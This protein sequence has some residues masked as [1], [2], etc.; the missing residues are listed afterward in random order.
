MEPSL[1]GSP[2]ERLT[3]AMPAREADTAPATSAPDSTTG[4]STPTSAAPTPPAAPPIPKEIP[5]TLQSVA[6]YRRYEEYLKS[7][8]GEMDTVFQQ[9]YEYEPEALPAR[10]IRSNVRQ[11]MDSARDQILADFVDE[12]TGLTY[13]D[14]NKIQDNM[15]VWKDQLLN[16]ERPPSAAY[17]LNA[18]DQELQANPQIAEMQARFQAHMAAMPPFTERWETESGS[19]ESVRPATEDELKAYAATLVDPVTGVSGSDLFH[20]DRSIQEKRQGDLAM[21]KLEFYK[22]GSF[23][24]DTRVT[25]IDASRVFGVIGRDQRAQLMAEQATS[26]MGVGYLLEG[27]GNLLLP[28]HRDPSGPWF[29]SAMSA[30]DLAATGVINVGHGGY[31]LEG[32]AMNGSAHIG[33][34]RPN[35]GLFGGLLNSVARILPG[36]KIGELVG[37]AV[38]DIN[39]AINQPA[40]SFLRFVGEDKDDFATQVIGHQE[41]T[42]NVLAHAGE[43]RG[44]TFATL[45]RDTAQYA[46]VTQVANTVGNALIATG[47]GA[48]VGAA[49][50]VGTGAMLAG[51]QQL[52]GDKDADGN[53]G[54]GQALTTFAVSAIT[55]GIGNGVTS[56]LGTATSTTAAGVTTTTVAA[57]TA[58]TFVSSTVNSVVSQAVTTGDVDLGEALAAGAL[59]AVGFN[60]QIAPGLNAVTLY[61]MGQALADGDANAIASLG[62]SAITGLSGA[63]SIYSG[64]QNQGLTTTTPDLRGLGEGDEQVANPGTTAPAQNSAPTAGAAP[65]PVAD[66]PEV[67]GPQ[68][69]GGPEAPEAGAGERPIQR[70]PDALDRAAYSAG[71]VVTEGPRGSTVITGPDGTVRTVHASG[72][73]VEVEGGSNRYV[74]TGATRGQAFE[75]ARAQ[76]LAVFEW[77]GRPYHTGREDQLNV[78]AQ[79]LLAA[80]PVLANLT[81]AERLQLVANAT[82][83]HAL[84]VF[85]SPDLPNE[86]GM[87]SRVIA[88]GLAMAESLGQARQE[89]DRLAARFPVPIVP[90]PDNTSAG[91][92]FNEGGESGGVPVPNPTPRQYRMSDQEVWDIVAQRLQEFGPLPPRTQVRTL[93]EA[94]ATVERVQQMFPNLDRGQILEAARRAFYSDDGEGRNTEPMFDRLLPPNR[95]NPEMLAATRI[96]IDALPAVVQD[97]DQLRTN[98]AHILAGGDPMFRGNAATALLFTHGGDAGQ[99]ALG[100][101]DETISMLGQVGPI[102]GR[103]LTTVNAREAQ[104]ILDSADPLIRDYLNR[105]ARLPEGVY[106]ADQF[107]GNNAAF[108]LARA[109]SGGLTLSQALQYIGQPTLNQP[110]LSPEEGNKP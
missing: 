91:G 14:I 75:A 23:T 85:R 86:P 39:H 11:T 82:S 24:G 80:N 29:I 89:T 41:A 19:G 33:T 83:Q 109:M 53:Q 84:N 50:V 45:V 67:G 99:V 95:T 36:G 56:S 88:A 71:S 4:V 51:Y 77:N 103:S 44:D 101:L 10:G 57:N 100:V 32:L 15:T 5:A 13:R 31:N 58:S 21:N 16:R 43:T 12:K 93:E 73:V 98:L 3:S 49:I 52:Q 62:T 42:T 55:A 60:T 30:S 18:R 27:D 2:A 72:A 25:D 97:G 40:S 78:E 81:E 17:G 79:R 20:L 92:L 48:A 38:S 9:N 90:L 68:S 105:V 102:V 70:P 61:N 65:G 104:Q 26:P 34:V 37:D 107:R 76:G 6:E 94:G 96:F 8:K 22:V 74:V 47:V 1:V 87:D 35:G 69:G 54:I 63:Q 28:S 46:E 106:S 110:I 64:I 66:D 59:G 7:V 108:A